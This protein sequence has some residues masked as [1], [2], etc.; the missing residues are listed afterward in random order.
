MGQGG[1]GSFDGSLVDCIICDPKMTTH[2]AN[3]FNEIGGI[4]QA[5]IGR[6]GCAQFEVLNGLCRAF[7]SIIIIILVTRRRNIQGFRE[8]ER[9]T[10]M[11][12]Q[13]QTGCKLNPEFA[14]RNG[15]L[16]NT[17]VSGR[18]KWSVAWAAALTLQGF[19]IRTN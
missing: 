18:L 9:Q 1:T 13:G 19:V 12:G 16:F 17:C 4:A 8:K 6:E 3:Q 14:T 10:Q 11:P 5:E 7:K 2:F 15:K